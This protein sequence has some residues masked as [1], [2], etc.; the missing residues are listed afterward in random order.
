MIIIIIPIQH[1]S[2]IRKGIFL[3]SHAH[4]L[5]TPIIPLICSVNVRINA[6]AAAGVIIC[7]RFVELDVFPQIALEVIFNI[8]LLCN[9]LAR[10][11]LKLITGVINNK[12]LER[13]R[14]GVTAGHHVVISNLITSFL[15]AAAINVLEVLVM[16]LL[17]VRML[18]VVLMLLVVFVDVV[19]D[20]VVGVLV[21]VHVVI[22]VGV[23]VLVGRLVFVESLVGVEMIVLVDVV[24]TV[25]DAS[26]RLEEVVLKGIIS[27]L[28]FLLG[29]FAL[30]CRQC[31]LGLLLSR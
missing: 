12:W 15:P 3:I 14:G 16:V 23:A 13:G 21:I 6:A 25:A 19:V 7:Y 28:L 2:F 1:K 9:C 29:F 10:S 4:G 11:L 30:Q 24:V 8:F 22:V 5:I 26:S 20:V 18:G 31:K 17:R 27:N